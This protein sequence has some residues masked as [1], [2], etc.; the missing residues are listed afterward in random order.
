MRRRFKTA[1]AAAVPAL[2]ALALLAGCGGSG[3]P[4]G[5]ETSA[6]PQASA[7]AETEAARLT[8]ARAF[9]TRVYSGYG[10]EG[11]TNAITNRDAVFDPTMLAIMKR[12]DAAQEAGDGAIFDFEPL[13]NCQD[14]TGMTWRITDAASPE[15]GKA[16][17]TVTRAFGA[18]GSEVRLTLVQV[19]D[20]WRIR[21]V[22]T[23]DV[24]SYAA[25]LEE[26]MRAEA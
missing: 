3:T 14:D 13:C 2:A 4:A 7:T 22:S 18:E 1:F 21:D 10:G 6:A 26:A 15:A 8:S 20:E 5:G 9:V 23:D 11:D 12:V 16:N 19:N 25:H 17:V 24:P